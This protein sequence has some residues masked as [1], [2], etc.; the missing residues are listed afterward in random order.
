M[1]TKQGLFQ[2]LAA[3]LNFPSYFG[4]NWDA[5]DECLSDLEW[6]PAAGYIIFIS[7]AGELLADDLKELK[8]LLH[9]LNKAGSFWATEKP[10]KPFRRL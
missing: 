6:L 9:V 4:K 2:E 3:A 5:L 8:I 7:E 10:P 1:R